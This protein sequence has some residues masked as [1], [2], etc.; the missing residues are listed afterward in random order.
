MSFNVPKN[1]LVAKGSMAIE[2]SIYAQVGT[3]ASTEQQIPTILF[4]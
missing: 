2:S 3:I 4:W 1:N